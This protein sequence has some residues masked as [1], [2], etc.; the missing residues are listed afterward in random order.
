MDDGE[1]TF[2]WLLQTETGNKFELCP[3]GAKLTGHRTCAEVGVIQVANVPVSWRQDEWISH[4]R[5][6]GSSKGTYLICLT[7]IGRGDALVGEQD[8]GEISLQYQDETRGVLARI[9]WAEGLGDEQLV[10][11]NL[12]SAG[13][14]FTI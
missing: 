12:E 13:I 14:T 5:L 2:D 6:I 7:M 11:F 8:E 4:P 1:H 9:K 10:E 3:H